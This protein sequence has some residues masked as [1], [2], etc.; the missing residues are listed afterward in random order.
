MN[1]PRLK[2][3]ASEETTT[4]ATG[5]LPFKGKSIY[6]LIRHL[7]SGFHPAGKNTAQKLTTDTRITSVYAADLGFDNTETN[8]RKVDNVQEVLR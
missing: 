2:S 7:L 6:L 1:L 3:R 4:S 8:A 5:N